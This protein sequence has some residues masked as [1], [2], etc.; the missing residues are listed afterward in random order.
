MFNIWQLNKRDRMF[1]MFGV[2]IVAF[3]GI[4]LL[5]ALIS[6]LI[7]GVD[8]STEIPQSSES[9]TEEQD[10]PVESQEMLLIY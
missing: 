3:I 10:E 1:F 2:I 4:S 7:S 8:S 6:Y 5:L 9:I